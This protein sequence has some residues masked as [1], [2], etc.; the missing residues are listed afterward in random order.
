MSATA[1]RIT[2]LL[3]D[4]YQR[5]SKDDGAAILYFALSGQGQTAPDVRGRKVFGSGHA[6][7]VAA[8][9]A[10]R[11]L[12]RGL[13]VTVYAAGWSLDKDMGQFVLVGVD[14]MDQ[15]A[16]RVPHEVDA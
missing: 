3:R 15:G 16:I 5:V 14:H 6:A 9:S 4:V 2:G 12:K 7:Q 1:V 13:P 11:R 8:T 10:V